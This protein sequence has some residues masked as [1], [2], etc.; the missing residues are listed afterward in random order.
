MVSPFQREDAEARPT[1][2]APGNEEPRDDNPVGLNLGVPLP[3]TKPL[4]SFIGNI[5]SQGSGDL[6]PTFYRIYS[7]YDVG[8]LKGENI[9]NVG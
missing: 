3:N 1:S 5:F 9:G 2:T 4:Y 6:E 8:V 7:D